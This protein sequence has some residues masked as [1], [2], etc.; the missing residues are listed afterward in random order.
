MVAVPASLEIHCLCLD[1]NIDMALPLSNSTRLSKV[2]PV[3]LH[4]KL[5]MRLFHF[6]LLSFTQS[7]ISA[8]RSG[9]NVWPH[10]SQWHNYHAVTISALNSISSSDID[11]LNKLRQIPWLLQASVSLSVEWRCL[12]AFAKWL[13]TWKKVSTC[14]GFL[15]CV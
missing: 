9:V 13:Q 3:A 8:N 10:D 14:Q 11:S 12:S 2:L 6:F 5:P 15:L 1:S 7:W 4:G